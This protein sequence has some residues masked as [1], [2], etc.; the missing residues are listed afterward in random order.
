MNEIV[1]MCILNAQRQTQ[2]RDRRNVRIIYYC[3]IYHLLLFN[4]GLSRVLVVRL[5]TLPHNP[6]LYPLFPEP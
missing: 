2:R 5:I 1:R 3:P 4:D 6:K